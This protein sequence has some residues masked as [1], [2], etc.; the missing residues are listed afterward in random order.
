V[1][2]RAGERALRRQDPPDAVVAVDVGGTVIKGALVASGHVVRR[3][4]EAATPP[5]G[6][7]EALLAAVVQ[8]VDELR[9]GPVAA[10]GVAVPGNVDSDSGT[11]TFA[12][13]LGLKDLQL[14][15]LLMSLLRVP[16]AVEQDG[17]AAALAE[18][19]LGAAVGHANAVVIAIG[20]GIAAGLITNGAVLRGASYRAGEL[21]HVPVVPGG[22]A[23]VCGMRGCAEAYAGGASMAR[24]YLEA[25]GRRATAEEVFAAAGAADRDAE[26]IVAEAV[27][28]LAA[29]TIGCIVSL[30]PALVLIGGGVSRAGAQLLDP[31][32]SRVDEA[33][34]WREAPP[35]RPAGLGPD[36]ALLGA[37]LVACDAA[38]GA[39]LEGTS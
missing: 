27:D 15:A 1:N 9:D 23:C 6:D 14:R 37:A 13:N 8:V 16:V 4:V 35:I 20:T 34:T 19:R 39:V 21:G 25:T 30:D 36:A 2:F 12:G 29:I 33:L 22:E 28:A 24:R 3:R 26:R 18:L 10:V 31:L 7:V 32:R 11:V 38:A 5:P 17:R